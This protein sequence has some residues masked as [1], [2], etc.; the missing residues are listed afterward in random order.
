MYL[1]V[2]YRYKRLPFS[3]NAASEIYQHEINKMLQGM[4]GVA[5]ISD[6]I[7]IHGLDEEH[8]ER[9]YQVLSKISMSGATLN[10]DKCLFGV[11]QLDF[12]GHQLSDKGIDIMREKVSAI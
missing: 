1:I 6:D 4:Q 10:W 11:N 8:D 12:F 7:I 9:L 5:N 2:V 3:V